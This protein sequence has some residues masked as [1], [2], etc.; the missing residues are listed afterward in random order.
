MDDRQT[1]VGGGVL[2]LVTEQALARIPGGTGRYTREV[3]QALGARIPFGW[4]VRGVTAWHRDIA[5]ARIPGVAG[6]RRLLL[7]PRVLARLWERGLGPRLGGTVVHALTPLAPARLRHRQALVMTVHDAVPYTH[8][9]TLTPRGAAWHRLMIERGARLASA[10]VVPTAAVAADL[11]SVGIRARIEVIGEG[12]ARALNGPIS[13]TE[14]ERMRTAFRL[15]GR[16]VLAV[17]T[18]EPRKGLDVLLDAL[19]AGDAA[20]VH[21]AVVGQPGWGGADLATAAEKRGIA[22]RVHVL[23][24][25]PDA[26]LAAVLAGAEVSVVPSRSEGF[27]LPLLEAMSRGIPVVHTDAPALL[28]VAGGA[29]LVVP[30]GNAAALGAA[31]TSVLADPDLAARLSEAGRV[32][33]A[34]YSWDAVAD[35]LWDLYQDV[36]AAPA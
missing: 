6:P 24:R 30:V 7:D 36:A 16:Y 11:E 1:T 4:R 13:A 21:L 9:E 29:G 26:E 15:P 17:G 32:R 27:G 12:T 3:G 19:T 10:L 14:I 23:G 35:R 33:A 25:I 28:E 18:L 8:P 34:A 31:I 5:S 2:T 20:A 22:D